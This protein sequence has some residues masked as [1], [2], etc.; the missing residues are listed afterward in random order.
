MV[1]RKRDMTAATAPVRQRPRHC[2]AQRTHRA[3][4]RPACSATLTGILRGALVVPTAHRVGRTVRGPRPR[5]VTGESRTRFTRSGACAA[6][7]SLVGAVVAWPA[8]AQPSEMTLVDLLDVPRLSDPRVSPDGGQ[9]VY[10]RSDA[11]WDENRRIGHLWRVDTDGS[12]TVQLTYG[13]G[14]RTARSG[15]SKSQRICTW[16]PARATV[17]ASSAIS[18]SK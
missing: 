1:G 8:A 7:M 5:P 11:D 4:R 17:G 12:G 6:A 2:R 15:A 18:C 16:R 10:V 14:E 9:L 3:A 13:A